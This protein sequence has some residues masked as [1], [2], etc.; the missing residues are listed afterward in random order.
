MKIKTQLTQNALL[1]GFGWSSVLAKKSQYA[2]DN[3]FDIIILC[4]II[5]FM[6]SK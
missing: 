3:S 6:W 5:R 2:R 4:F 1:I